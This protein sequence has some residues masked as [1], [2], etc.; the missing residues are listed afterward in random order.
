MNEE[1][2]LNS[3]SV[4]RGRVVSLHV[5]QV[6]LPNGRQTSREVMDHP[7]AVAIV[8]VHKDGRVT[9][10]RQ[11]R[12]AVGQTLLE[13]PAGTLAPGEDPV[14]AASR[15]LAEETGLRSE[16]FEPLVGFY[17][18]PG[19]SSEYLWV[20]MAR[21]LSSCVGQTE[22]DEFIEVVTLPL[23]QA[24]DLVG[25]GDIRD[26]KS[27]IGLVLARDHLNENARVPG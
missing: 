27:I 9:L 25:R 6:S 14:E 12:Y 4:Y 15:E 16:R 24:L 22:E 3:R 13:I 10:V 18:S 20:Y 8:P 1:I 2:C 21:E 7:G 17:P 19:V 11:Y 26:S 5:D 23:N